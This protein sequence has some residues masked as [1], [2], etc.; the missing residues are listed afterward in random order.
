M[1]PIRPGILCN[2]SSLETPG[3]PNSLL[4]PPTSAPYQ[5]LSGARGCVSPL[6]ETG[7]GKS[8]SFP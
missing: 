5:A 2:I 6:W 3:L 4:L 1:L 8:L 7:W